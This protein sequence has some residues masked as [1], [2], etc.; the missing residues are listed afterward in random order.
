[1]TGGIGLIEAVAVV[2]VFLAGG[3][4]GMLLGYSTGSRH[5]M[6]IAEPVI[7]RLAQR[8]A[9]QEPRDAQKGD[10]GTVTAAQSGVRLLFADSDAFIKLN[11]NTAIKRFKRYYEQHRVEIDKAIVENRGFRLYDPKMGLFIEVY[12]LNPDEPEPMGLV[13][14]HEINAVLPEQI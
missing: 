14:F 8:P 1:M 11:G 4:I 2:I 6:E 10:G 9:P 13:R 3:F 7:R 5:A 12:R